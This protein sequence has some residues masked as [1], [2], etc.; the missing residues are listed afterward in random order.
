MSSI[1]TLEL[2]SERL[3]DFSKTKNS[4]TN[5]AIS[6][7]PTANKSVYRLQTQNFKKYLFFLICLNKMQELSLISTF[8]Y[9][10]IHLCL[11]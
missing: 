11:Q 7:K 5:L 4:S 1:E 10:T 9:L 6:P 2:S 3:G 8:N